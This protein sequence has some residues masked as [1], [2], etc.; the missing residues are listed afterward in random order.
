M[1]VAGVPPAEGQTSLRGN[2]AHGV[3]A[4]NFYPMSQC[5]HVRGAQRGNGSRGAPVTCRQ[6]HARPIYGPLRH[7]RARQS[8]TGTWV[9][10]RWSVVAG[11]GASSPTPRCS[12]TQAFGAPRLSARGARRAEEASGLIGTCCCRRCQH[13]C[14]LLRLGPPPLCMY[15]RSLFCGVSSGEWRY[16]QPRRH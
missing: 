12:T 4:C 5:G 8:Y 14:Q 13:P 2:T 7:R 10:G 16:V 11:G 9:C 3:S 15:S 6:C 1:Q